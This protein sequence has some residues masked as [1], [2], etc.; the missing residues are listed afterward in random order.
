M[1]HCR[2]ALHHVCPLC[3]GPALRVHRYPADYLAGLFQWVRRYRCGR[4]ECQWEGLLGRYELNLQQA[5][6]GAAVLLIE[7]SP[8]RIALTSSHA[9]RFLF[10]FSTAVL[11]FAAIVLAAG[12]GRQPQPDVPWSGAAQRDVP[13]LA[14][15]QSDEGL[16]LAGDDLRAAATQTSLR[17]RRACSWGTPGS[18]PYRGTVQQALH[19]AGLPAD[20]VQALATKVAAGEWVDR[21]EITRNGIRAP[22]SGRTFSATVPAMAFGNLLCF[23]TRVNFEPGH[24]ERGDLYEAF[25]KTGARYTIMVPYVCGNVSVLDERGESNGDCCTVPEPGTLLMIFAAL[26][27]LATVLFR[28]RS[29][30]RRD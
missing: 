6:A 11:V 17:L 18:N 13:R 1:R 7:R 28:R 10:G 27:V 30:V 20:A 12:A 14:P 16:P 19:A 8:R 22:Q 29:G 26:V 3:G 9:S 25:A 2:A 21:V 15:G 5:H 24:V 4:I 23:N